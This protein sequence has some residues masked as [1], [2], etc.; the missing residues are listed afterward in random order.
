METQLEDGPMQTPPWLERVGPFIAA[1]MEDK[2]TLCTA[3]RSTRCLGHFS[4][5]VCVP[6]E[7]AWLLDKCSYCASDIACEVYGHSHIVCDGYASVCYIGTAFSGSTDGDTISYIWVTEPE[8][9][10][11]GSCASG[12]V[13]A[14]V[15]S[16]LDWRYSLHRKTD[17]IWPLNE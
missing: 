1:Y 4:K 17:H 14:A 7:S 3:S 9:L 8:V 6:S 13:S 2:N 5:F 10:L 11:C 15:Q 16:V 12:S